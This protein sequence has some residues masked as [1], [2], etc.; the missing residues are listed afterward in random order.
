MVTIGRNPLGFPLIVALPKGRTLDAEYYRDNIL[1]ALTQ[2]QPGD[3]RRKLVVHDDNARARTAQ[4][5]R[6]FCEENGLRIATHPPDSRLF[7]IFIS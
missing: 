4:K 5:G 2:F 7:S 6:T 3:D 1:A